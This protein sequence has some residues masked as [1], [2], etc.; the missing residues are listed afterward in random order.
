[1][2]GNGSAFLHL[3]QLIVSKVTIIVSNVTTSSSSHN[4]GIKSSS[5]YSTMII[6]SDVDY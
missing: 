5:N 2:P 3:H 6:S 4:N 1:M